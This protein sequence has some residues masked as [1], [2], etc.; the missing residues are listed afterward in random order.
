[1]ARSRQTSPQ[2]EALRSLIAE[3]RAPKPGRPQG[4]S[5]R[6]IAARLGLGESTVRDISTGRRGVTPQKAEA[7]LRTYEETRPTIE[8]LTRRHASILGTYANLRQQARKTGDPGL[9]AR[10]MGKDVVVQT[11]DGPLRLETDPAV[12]RAQAD[13]GIDPYRDIRIDSPKKARRRRRA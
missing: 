11:A 10:R 13:A 6:T 1:M 2:A 3:M 5:T 9:V 12:L 7:A 8:T 4:I